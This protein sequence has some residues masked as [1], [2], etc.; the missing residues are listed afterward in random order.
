MSKTWLRLAEAVGLV[1]AVNW[2]SVNQRSNMARNGSVSRQAFDRMGGQAYFNTKG[3]GMAQ[4]A[5]PPMTPDPTVQRYGMQIPGGADRPGQGNPLMTPS[6]G[7]S[8]LSTSPNSPQR[9]GMGMGG[10]DDQED[11]AY[12]D[13][14][15]SAESRSRRRGR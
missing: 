11:E 10:P 15:V 12:E 1:D 2:R 4:G 7:P 8:P 5:R 9:M 6:R 3:T 14:E 13:L